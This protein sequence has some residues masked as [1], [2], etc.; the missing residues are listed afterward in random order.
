MTQFFK[1]KNKQFNESGSSH[2]CSTSTTA[3]MLN[4]LALP[5][6]CSPPDQIAS[7]VLWRVQKGHT[8][9]KIH[10][11]DLL[12]NLHHSKRMHNAPN[13]LKTAFRVATQTHQHICSFYWSRY[14]TAYRRTTE[15]IFYCSPNIRLLLFLR[16]SFFLR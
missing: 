5:V 1:K 12:R 11:A 6:R 8:K 16:F 2:V 9:E 3:N 14:P 15:H 4:M 13:T 10:N 7:P